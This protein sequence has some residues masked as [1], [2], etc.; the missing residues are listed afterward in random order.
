M[1]E[2]VR[3]KFRIFQVVILCGPGR[4]P[5]VTRITAIARRDDWTM[6]RVPEYSVA[7]G[8]AVPETDIIGGRRLKL[9]VSRWPRQPQT[10]VPAPPS[11]S[12]GQAPAPQPAARPT[13]GY[14]PLNFS[15]WTGGIS[16]YRS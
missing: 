3:P 13:P 11:T 7:G 12:S 2:R 15:R 1:N 9:A 10:P 5:V 14:R 8:R 6:P 4:R 16:S